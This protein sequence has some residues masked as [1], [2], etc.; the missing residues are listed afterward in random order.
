MAHQVVFVESFMVTSYI[1]KSLVPPESKNNHESM[2]WAT[3]SPQIPT[4]YVE[5]HFS[6]SPSMPTT[7]RSGIFRLP[8]CYRRIY[9]L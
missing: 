8:V 1:N 9:R 2:S 4:L 5:F 7:I 6:I 3:F